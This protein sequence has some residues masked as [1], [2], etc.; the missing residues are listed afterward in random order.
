MKRVSLAAVGLAALLSV[1]LSGCGTTAS[2]P[3]DSLPSAP[4]SEEATVTPSLSPQGVYTDKN[5][6]FQVTIPDD[7]I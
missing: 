6:S 3:A 1:A 4:V 2:V 7:Y 5:K